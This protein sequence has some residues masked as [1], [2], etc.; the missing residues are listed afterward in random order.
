[1]PRTYEHVN[2]YER[3][4]IAQMLRED[5]G[6]SVIGR[7]LGRAPSTIYREYRRNRTADGY[8]PRGADRVAMARRRVAR[9][10]RRMVGAVRHWVTRGL[11]GYWSPEQI[12]GRG[13]REGRSSLS[14]MTIYRYLESPHGM[15]YRKY[16]RGPGKRRRHNRKFRER[17]H[18]RV[19]IDQRPKQVE[20]RKQVGHWEGDTVRGP[21]KSSAC[22]MSLVERKSQFL[23]SRLLAERNGETLNSSAHRAVKHLPFE[24]LTVDNGMEFASHKKLEQLTGASIYFAHEKCPWER[25]LNEQVNG[26]L[27]QFFPKGTDFSR[28]SPAQLRRAVRLINERPRKSLGYRT[29]KEVMAKHGFALVK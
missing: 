5:S 17:I 11:K 25:G 7:R 15:R 13:A 21:M 26:L 16:L 3:E 8:M 9:R 28:V 18:D 20:A 12:E 19:M 1:M 24:T 6:W 27:R 29:P 23:V 2:G 22:L 10:P 4:V 14:L